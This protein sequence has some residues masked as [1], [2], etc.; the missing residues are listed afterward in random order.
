MEELIRKI[1]NNEIIKRVDFL[2]DEY[3]KY[4]QNY[5]LSIIEK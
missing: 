5:S 3:E 2:F 1:K 4:D